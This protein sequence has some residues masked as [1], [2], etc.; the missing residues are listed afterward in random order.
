VLSDGSQIEQTDNSI[1]ITKVDILHFNEEGQIVV[2]WELY[3]AWDF[4]IQLGLLVPQEQ[5]Q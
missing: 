4:M 2:T 5:A 1:D 3:D